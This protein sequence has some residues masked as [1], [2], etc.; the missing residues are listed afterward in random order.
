MIAALCSTD[1]KSCYDRV[2]HWIAMIAMRRIGVP[3]EPLNSLFETIQKAVHSIAIENNLS[4]DV[5]DAAELKKPIHGLGQGNG[6][7]P[8]IW[9]MVSAILV[10]ILQK[11]GHGLQLLSALSNTLTSVTGF[12]FVDDLD[13]VESSISPW[14]DDTSITQRMQST[15]SRWAGILRASGGKLEPSK[16]FWY[17]AK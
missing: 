11:K 3:N 17:L 9:V 2:I 1:A 13:L 7:A 5:Y 4:K 15:V 12:M 10:K 16:S 14:A 6:A 8:M